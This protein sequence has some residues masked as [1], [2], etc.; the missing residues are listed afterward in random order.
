[1]FLAFLLLYNFCGI[2]TLSNQRL[3]LLYIHAYVALVQIK[4]QKTSQRVGYVKTIILYQK[5]QKPVFNILLEMS[6]CLP[7]PMDRSLLSFL[8]DNR[9]I[10]LAVSFYY[11][12]FVNIIKLLYRKASE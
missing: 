8:L 4:Q 9:L 1:L 10:M 11:F 5:H 6:A 7:A 2:Y 3:N 12:F